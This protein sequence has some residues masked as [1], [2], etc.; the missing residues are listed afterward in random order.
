MRCKRAEIDINIAPTF[1]DDKVR[2]GAVRCG[3]RCEVLC[4]GMP[5]HYDVCRGYGSYNARFA[6]H[7]PLS[8]KLPSLP[9]TRLVVESI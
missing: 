4:S 8:G 5:Q 3:V 2:C 7:L 6:N 1:D 9:T